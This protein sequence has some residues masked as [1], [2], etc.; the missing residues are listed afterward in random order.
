MPSAVPTDKPFALVASG[1]HG[2]AVSAVNGCAAR[3]GVAIG[4][5]LADARAAF[6][7]LISKPAEPPADRLALLR[8]AR[9][10]GRYGPNRHRDGDDGLWIDITGVAHLFGGEE[11]LLD[12]VT[13]RLA[14]FG[15]P[16]CAGLADTLGAAARAGALC[17]PDGASWALALERVKRAALLRRCRLKRCGWM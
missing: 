17:R 14:S 7:N 5:A 1:V 12:D 8:L 9:W 13:R 2:L 10:A 4:T 3:E 15:V 16:A 11:N 6:P